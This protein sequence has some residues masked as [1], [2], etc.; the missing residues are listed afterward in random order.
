MT[1]EPTPPDAPVTNTTSLAL[2][3]GPGQQVFSCG[4]GAGK[5]CEFNATEF[6]VDFMSW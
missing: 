2:T 1:A 5:G 4:I 6:A 3:V